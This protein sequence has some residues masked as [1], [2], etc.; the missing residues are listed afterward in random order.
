MGRQAVILAGG[1]GT[2]LSH[3]V[4]D[5]PKPM[6][7]V[8]QI[9]FLDYIIKVLKNNGFD[10]FVFLTGYKSE[11]IENYYKELGN[12]VFVKEETALG[13]GGALLNAYRHLAD[14]FFVINGDT[15][16]DIDYS[17][18]E[19]FGKNKPCSI[20]LRYT[21]NVK[22][23]GFV[24][25]NEKFKVTSFIEKGELPENRIDGYINGGIYY[26]KKSVLSNFINSFKG[27][28]ISL[29]TEIFSEI[30]KN[31]QLYAVP[32][33]GYFIDIGI[34]EDYYKAQNS[35][36]EWMNKKLK[37]ALFIDKDGTLI[38][39][40]EYPHGK[41]FSII[42]STIDIVKRYSEL[43]YYLIIVTNQA[44]IAKNKFNFSQMY[45]GFEGIK[46]YYNTNF[47]IKF[48]DIEYCPYHK[49]GIIKEYSHDSLLRKPNPGMILK[50]CEKFKID[51]KN[52][53]MIGDN[54][55]ID[56]IHLPYLKCE[57][58]TGV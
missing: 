4:S 5:V 36:P 32:V 48:D 44:G 7:P 9:P 2:R 15:F 21:Q 35:I 58:L 25:I 51:L 42:Q 53:I 46:E 24:E 47:G 27:E 38:V 50:A 18:L 54:T 57:I 11:I 28:F 41:D 56:K 8:K 49:D 31:G 37:P 20:A 6:A 55:E 52:S 3:I 16:F 26:I 10:N 12:A 13:T 30:L 40:T 34:P 39:N 22:R 1:F 23:Y 45:E 33:G 29:E 14:E 17:L 19:N 43:N